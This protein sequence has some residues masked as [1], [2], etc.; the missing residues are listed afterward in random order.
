MSSDTRNSRSRFGRKHCVASLKGGSNTALAPTSEFRGA[1]GLVEGAKGTRLS[2]SREAAD[3][4]AFGSWRVRD[5]RN[6]NT[7]CSWLVGCEVLAHPDLILRLE[8]M[9]DDLAEC[10]VAFELEQR[11]RAAAQYFERLPVC[12]ARMVARAAG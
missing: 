12:H 4:L 5:P 2:L 8:L 10:V 9:T 3:Q 11:D 6:W 7:D 1:V